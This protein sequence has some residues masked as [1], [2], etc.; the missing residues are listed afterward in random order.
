MLDFVEEPP[1]VLALVKTVKNGLKNILNSY[2]SS[3]Y[4]MDQEI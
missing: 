3:K 1:V 2:N 4:V